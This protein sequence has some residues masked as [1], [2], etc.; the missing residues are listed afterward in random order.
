MNYKWEKI[1]RFPFH[2]KERSSGT[3]KGPLWSTLGSIKA[4]T[5]TVIYCSQQVLFG[6]ECDHS[7]IASVPSWSPHTKMFSKT[8]GFPVLSSYACGNGPLWAE[9]RKE[10]L[11]NCIAFDFLN[12]NLWIEIMF[13]WKKRDLLLEHSF[14][15][16]NKKNNLHCNFVSNKC[17]QHKPQHSC[18]L[19][20]VLPVRSCGTSLRMKT[21][22]TALV[23]HHW[24]AS[25][26]LPSSA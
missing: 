11:H 7:P 6:C 10:D 26:H 15:V 22:T 9:K 3:V 25:C 2:P 24:K 17:E 20:F 4:L 5:R 8:A 18:F 19:L 13:N 23:Q 21:S 16:I 14:S 1:S 12:V